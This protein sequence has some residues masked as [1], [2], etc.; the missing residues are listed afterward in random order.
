MTY[1]ISFY[2][3]PSFSLFR[4]EMSFLVFFF[5]FFFQYVRIIKQKKITLGKVHW[6]RRDTCQKMTQ[7]Y[8]HLISHGFSWLP[9]FA[10]NF[11]IFTL[12]ISVEGP[13]LLSWCFDNHID[14]RPKYTTW[15]GERTV[16][17]GSKWAFKQAWHHPASFASR[18]KAWHI[19][20]LL[21]V[22]SSC[23][24][25]EW[26][27]I[28]WYCGVLS[29]TTNLFYFKSSDISSTVHTVWSS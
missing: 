2:L 4:I 23:N 16:T 11:A 21:W 22:I 8:C 15:K 9:F 5:F 1:S 3:S 25:V 24:W 28:I 12:H 13:A 10:G 18:G 27:N 17:K 29:G 20:A 26:P 6:Y 19:G 14:K 7:S